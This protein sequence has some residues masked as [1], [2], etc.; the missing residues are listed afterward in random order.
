MKHIASITS[1]SILTNVQ[2]GDVQPNAC[3]VRLGKVFQ[4]NNSVFELTNDSKKHRGSE[5]ILPDLEGFYT[6]QPGA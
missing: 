6:L 2:E 4:I 5:E 3:D 1:K